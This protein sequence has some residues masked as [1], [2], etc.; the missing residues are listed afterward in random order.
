[1]EA[2]P[3]PTPESTALAIGRSVSRLFWHLTQTVFLNQRAFRRNL[4]NCEVY[5]FQV[6]EQEPLRCSKAIYAQVDGRHATGADALRQAIRES[7]GFI[8]RGPLLASLHDPLENALTRALN[9]RDD[10]GDP[11]DKERARLVQS[12]IGSL[13]EPLQNQLLSSVNDGQGQWLRLGRLLDEECAPR[14]SPIT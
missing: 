4:R 3:A 2:P 13:V 8:E 12:E 9:A 1:M 6:I 10:D 5:A 7:V 14:M 11:I